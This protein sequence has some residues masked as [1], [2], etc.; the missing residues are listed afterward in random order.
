MNFQNLQ[1]KNGATYMV[2]SDGSDVVQHNGGVEA[3]TQYIQV[4]H[5]LEPLL[6]LLILLLLICLLPLLL[7]LLL[8]FL[9]PLLLLLL[10]QEAPVS[11]GHDSSMIR[12]VGIQDKRPGGSVVKV[13][14]QR[15][16]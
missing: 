2:T 9:L 6:L 1:D 13:S 7:L 11:N 8:I 10:P 12:I 5:P 4:A 15:C 16:P 3:H 14:Q